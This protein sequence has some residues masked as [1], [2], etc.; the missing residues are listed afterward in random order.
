MMPPGKCAQQV[1]LQTAWR[2]SGA[3]AAWIARR[4]DSFCAGWRSPIGWTCMTYFVSPKYK[5]AWLR[6]ARLAV[7][8]LGAM[9][10]AGDHGGAPTALDRSVGAFEPRLTARR[11]P[12]TQ[13]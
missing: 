9:M 13:R 8:S 12:A 6:P 10:A 11:L 1:E 4:Y 5:Q 3:L 7:V 2:P